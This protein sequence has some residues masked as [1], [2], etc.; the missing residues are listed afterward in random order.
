M[1]ARVAATAAVIAAVAILA[2]LIFS[3]ADSYE[4]RAVF[5]NAGQLVK[6]NQVEVSGQS[7]GSITDIRLTDNGH[8]EVVMSLNKFTPLHQGTT[9][10]IRS[11]SGRTRT[12]SCRAAARS[13]PTAP[14]HRSTSTSSSTPS[15]A[16]PA[17]RCGF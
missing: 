11:T 10:T 17:S 2:I 3:G 6:G 4:A 13:P 1:L 5:Q 9:A 8:A 15:T 16:R 7:I 14:P 12:T